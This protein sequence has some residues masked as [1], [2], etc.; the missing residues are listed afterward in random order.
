[1]PTTLN[2]PETGIERYVQNIREVADLMGIP[3]G[4]IKEAYTTPSGNP[5]GTT[6]V[7][8]VQPD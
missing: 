1:M 7:I 8:L 3:S 5:S 6:L 2:S 4:T